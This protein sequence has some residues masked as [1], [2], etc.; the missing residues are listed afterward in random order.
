MN[1]IFSPFGWGL[2]VG[3]YILAFVVGFMYRTI[4]KRA[5]IKS[6]RGVAKNIGTGDRLVRLV[7][8]I[9]LLLLAITTTWSPV[10]IFFS[11]F[12]LFEALFSWC[13]FYAAIGKNTCPAY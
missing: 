4:L 7:I 6:P 1:F 12:A 8:G 11:G 9:A 2:I 13:G 3:M 10:L 5:E